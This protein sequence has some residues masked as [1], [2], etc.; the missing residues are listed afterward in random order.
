MQSKRRRQNSHNT[1]T[2]QSN[3]IAIEI[4]KGNP[5]A[6][7]IIDHHLEQGYIF[8]GAEEYKYYN[9]YWFDKEDKPLIIYNL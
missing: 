8:I 7:K 6:R 2:M 5:D 3:L 4:F 9:L 1:L